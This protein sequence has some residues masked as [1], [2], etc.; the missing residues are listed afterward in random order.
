MVI[1]LIIF[2]PVVSGIA[3]VQDKKKVSRVY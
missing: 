3:G 2:C 1:A